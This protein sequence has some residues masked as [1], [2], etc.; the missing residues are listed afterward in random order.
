MCFCRW[1]RFRAWPWGSSCSRRMWSKPSA[2]AASP[3][4]RT[5]AGYLWSPRGG[6]MDWHRTHIWHGLF[7]NERRV[8]QA[9]STSTWR[10]EGGLQHQLSE[11]RHG[12]TVMQTSKSLGAVIY[13]QVWCF[14][15]NFGVLRFWL[16]NNLINNNLIIKI[17][18]FR[19]A[20]W[21]GRTW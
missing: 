2:G 11:F 19:F 18:V 12:N 1:T 4:L 14:D 20:D 21:Y 8:F 16:E 17:I 3:H 15:L 6:I 5:M 7:S 13:K 9:E 10:P